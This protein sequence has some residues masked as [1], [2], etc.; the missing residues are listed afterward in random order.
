MQEQYWP[1][2]LESPLI[3]GFAQEEI[4]L[5]LSLY[6]NGIRTYKKNEIIFEAGEKVEEIG[7][8]LDGDVDTIQEDFWGNQMLLGRFRKGQIFA[9]SFVLASAAGLPFT[10]YSVKKSAV[11]FLDYKRMLEPNPKIC[12]MHARLTRNLLSISAKKNMFLLRKINQLTRRTVR[13]KIMA[14]LSAEA[15]KRGTSTFTIQ[16][17]RQSMAD[18]LGIDRSSLSSELSRLQKEGVLSYY[19]NSFTLHKPDEEI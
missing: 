7:V 2:L 10:V 6:Q 17:N 3:E 9:D 5:L 15:E 1:I 8:I 14:Y 12:G 19:K 16:Y 18:Y 13:E 11:L 4:A